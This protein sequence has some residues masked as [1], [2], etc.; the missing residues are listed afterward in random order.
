[1]PSNWSKRPLAGFCV[2]ALMNIFSVMSINLKSRYDTTI[3][4]VLIFGIF[5]PPGMEIA[6][7]LTM[8][9]TRPHADAK[10]SGYFAPKP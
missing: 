5:C 10:G 9:A 8:P 7:D 6:K 4:T 1:M 3:A 2:P